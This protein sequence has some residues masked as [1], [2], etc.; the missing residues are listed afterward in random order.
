MY[1]KR[2]YEIVET[3]PK[4]HMVKE[5]CPVCGLDKDSFDAAE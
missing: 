2:G 1:K 5:L 3:E 4:L